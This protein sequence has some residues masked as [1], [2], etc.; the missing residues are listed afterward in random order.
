MWIYQFNLNSKLRLI[1]SALN[2]VK[3]SQTF[4][5]R[6]EI[7]YWSTIFHKTN[8]KTH[9]TKFQ[10]YN[11]KIQSLKLYAKAT[12]RN[13]MLIQPHCIYEEGWHT[14]LYVL[15]NDDGNR[16]ESSPGFYLAAGRTTTSKTMTNDKLAKRKT[17]RR[18]KPGRIEARWRGGLVDLAFDYGKP[19]THTVAS[20]V[21]LCGNPRNNASAPGGTYLPNEKYKNI[22][23]RIN[24]K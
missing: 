8:K 1:I 9:K 11:R 12:R 20:I 21:K 13:I 14:Q 7:R 19:H 5:A 18:Y 3:L 2:P 24:I 22:P 23:I 6:N 10:S 4:L 17:R 16:L 15:T